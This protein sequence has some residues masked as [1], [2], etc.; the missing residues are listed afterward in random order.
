[1]SVAVGICPFAALMHL[2]H[3][4]D[5]SVTSHESRKQPFNLDAIQP[6]PFFEQHLVDI[7]SAASKVV[8]MLSVQLI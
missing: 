5:E 2:Q 6:H 1:M 4:I 3:D 8:A 7:V